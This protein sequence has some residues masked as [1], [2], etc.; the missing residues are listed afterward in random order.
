MESTA[1]AEHPRCLLCGATNALGLKLDLEVQDDGSVVAAFP[2]RELLQSYP[3]TL[4]GGVISAVLDAA[5]TNVL[6]SIG[7][8]AVTAELT[9]RFLAPV[10]VHRVA[11]VRA[12]IE[13]SAA[14]PL[15]LVRAEL[16]QDGRARARAAAKFLVRD[17]R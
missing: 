3:E 7:I 13:S 6:F 9:V 11:V 5:M 10:S 4:H 12:S 14:H 2:C 16:E 17:S 8:V 15:Y 1:A